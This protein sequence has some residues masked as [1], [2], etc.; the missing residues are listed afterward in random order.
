MQQCKNRHIL[1]EINAAYFIA[2]S[3][4][5]Y[6]RCRECAREYKRKMK[7]SLGRRRK[8]R[9]QSADLILDRTNSA[10]QKKGG[11]SRTALR[12]VTHKSV[13]Q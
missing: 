8:V 2:K 1:D 3:G 12:V 6:V 9:Q 7:R 5:M 10:A 4:A 13:G 11:N